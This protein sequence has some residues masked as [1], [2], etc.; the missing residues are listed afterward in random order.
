MDGPFWDV[1]IH[2]A[3]R[4]RFF[5]NIP[6]ELSRAIMVWRPRN[7]LLAG[8]P[9]G[10]VDDLP[11]L[12]VEGEVVACRADWGGGR[13]GGEGPPRRRLGNGLAH[14]GKGL[15]QHDQCYPKTMT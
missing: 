8:E 1:Q 15:G 5:D 7:D 4:V 3:E 2:E 13:G 10:K 9:L 6:R 11:F 12:L 14:S